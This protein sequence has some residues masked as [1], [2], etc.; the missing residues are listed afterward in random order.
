MALWIHDK[1]FPG[2]YAVSSCERT[3]NRL[4]QILQSIKEKLMSGKKSSALFVLGFASALGLAWLVRYSRE[5]ISGLRAW[6][7]VLIRRHGVEKAQS[8]VAAIRQQYA[9]LIT[10]NRMPE[11]QA[12]HWHL[13]RKILPGLA[14]YRVLVREQ[15]GDQQAALDEVNEAFRSY[16]LSKSHMLFA[17]LKLLP[18]S[19]PL[20]KLIFPQMMKAFPA[21]G[22]DFTYLENSHDR[23]AFNATRCFYLNTLTAH[24]APELTASFCKTDDV[25]AEAFPS[26]IRFVRLHTL[27]RG[28]AVCDFQ[29]C[30]A[31]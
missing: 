25:M 10:E 30:R 21:E 16:T 3:V 12:L 24:G 11:N 15:A 22:W 14:L 8:Q 26:S 19:F 28:D 7:Q 2:G 27:G 9:T 4:L 1:L 13:R 5:E 6:R 18:N 31:K 20:F 23:V 29:Y 17:P